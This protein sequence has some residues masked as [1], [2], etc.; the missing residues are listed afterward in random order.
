MRDVYAESQFPIDPQLSTVFDAAL[1]TSKS[2]DHIPDP[3]LEVFLGLVDHSTVEPVLHR[4]GFSGR[5]IRMVAGQVWAPPEMPD[6][7]EIPAVVESPSMVLMP[8]V[9][10]AFVESVARGGDRITPRDMTVAFL[11]QRPKPLD[12]VIGELETKLKFNVDQAI[13]AIRTA[14]D[15]FKKTPSMRI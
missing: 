13:T 14:P 5:V 2:F 8:V 11:S 1:D 4:M 7:S 3:Q 9:M 6:P 12:L 10:G 15:G